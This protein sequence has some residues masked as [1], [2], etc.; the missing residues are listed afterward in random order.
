MSG[1]QFNSE[2]IETEY[3]Y[4]IVGAG[5]AGSVLANR[6]S[7]QSD[8]KVLLVEAGPKDGSWQLSMPAALA[9][10]LRGTRFNWAYETEPQAELNNRTLFWPRGRVLGGSSSINGMV[11][12]RGH[13]RDYDN[14]YRQGLDGWAYAE[15]LPYFKRLEAWSE[16]GNTYRGGDGLV[17]IQRGSYPNPL[18]DA[19]IEAGGAAGFPVSEDFNGHQFE[20]FGRFD[21]NIRKG[22]RQSSSETYLR[23]ARGR[24]NLTVLTN[25]LTSRVL[26]SNGAA[27][28]IEYVRGRDRI[29]VRATREVILCGGAIN[30]PQMLQ[31]S[32]IGRADDLKQLG[33]PVVQDLP[34][35][36]ENLQDHLNTSVKYECLQPV[37]LYGADK[38][39][40]NALIGLQYMLFKTGAGATMHTEAGCFVKALPTSDIPDIQHHFIPI[41]VYDN[42]RTPPD[43][44]GFQCHVCPL[45][46]ESRGTVRLRSDDPATPPIMQPNCMTTD[47]DTQL[48]IASIKTTRDAMNQKPMDPYRGAE[49]FPGPDVR[50]DAEILDYVRQS[51]VTCYHPVGTCKMGTDEMGVVDAEMRVH[52]VEGL[53]IVDASI[54]PELVSGNTNAPIMMMA[55]K[56]AD[57]MLAIPDEAPLDVDYAGYA[58]IPSS[59][60]RPKEPRSLPS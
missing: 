50:T 49:L 39:P 53:R 55:E 41:L 51:A 42:G 44:H 2:D 25:C 8:I 32:G 38:F 16:G 57:R 3:D 26:T 7:E 4:I 46:P 60:L 21:M 5:S 33:I 54:M 31:L 1:P 48:M 56:I 23:A 40:R 22:R 47:H 20:G 52:G 18:F 10:P 13:A 34:G 6:L 59:E 17:G 37:S 27:V 36:G 24:T 35:V 12:I 15:V 14:W 43:R 30:S 19:Y 9:Y 11:W 29:S 45:R 58:P 28:G